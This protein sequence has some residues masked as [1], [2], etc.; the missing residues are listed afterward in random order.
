M[1]EQQDQKKTDAAPEEKSWDELMAEAG[2]KPARGS[3][4]K[5]FTFILP[6]GTGKAKQDKQP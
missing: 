1:S 2:I 4:G 5:A 6:V 3:G